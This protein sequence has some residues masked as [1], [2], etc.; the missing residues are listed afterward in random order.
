[1]TSSSTLKSTADKGSELPAKPLIWLTGGPGT[2]TAAALDPRPEELGGRAW[3]PAAGHDS[4]RIGPI[5]AEFSK[6]FPGENLFLLHPDCPL[7][8]GELHQLSAWLQ[9]LTNADGHPLALTALSNHSERFNPFHNLDVGSAESPDYPAGLVSLLGTQAF[10][11]ASDWPDHLVC[12]NA[13][14]V[15]LLA[16]ESVTAANALARLQD[17]GGTL[18]CSDSLFLHANNH[19]LLTH[20]R[21][22]H[23]E[24]AQLPAWSELSARLSD[25]LRL[26]VEWLGEWPATLSHTQQ[27][28]T[29]HITHSWGGGVARWV[30]NLIDTDTD[31]L[32]FQLR[33]ERAE[34]G[35][36]AGQKLALY[37]GNELGAALASWNLQPAIRSS[38]DQHP[39]Y[40]QILQQTCRRYRI[41]RIIVSSLVGHSL[42]ALRS[43]L[44][45]VQV[46]HDYYP[47]WPLLGV[48]PLPYLQ[49]S[50]TPLASAMNEHPLLV[51]FGARDA[52]GWQEL[53]TRWRQTLQQQRVKLAAPSQSVVNLLRQLDSGWNDHDIRVIPHGLTPFADD[54]PVLPKA[55][56]DGRLRLVIPGRM[57]T[58]KGQALLL[59]ALPELTKVAQVYLL[60]TGK[61]G[62]AFFGHSGVNVILQYER[63]DLPAILREIGPHLAALLSVVPETFSYTLSEMRQLNIPVL[64]TRVGSLAERIEDGHDGWLIETDAAA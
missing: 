1:M 30:S 37:A 48:N 64:A 11:P 3:I 13:A 26:P 45:T 18:L 20:A 54:A 60:G 6:Q 42:D 50:P 40:P 2:V 27:A 55:R 43:G 59:Q 57:Q 15:A 23:H 35:R 12:L 39:F 34:S 14:A 41:G 8:A 19:E 47:L 24:Q 17:Q 22:E 29:L 56:T 52:A 32:H 62:E 25:W 31:G 9:Q 49:A 44:P 5:L 10:V 61:D 33:S 51:D 21:L 38:L 36:G 58:L 7:Q 4:A 63:E 53:A 16:E 28:A 46:L